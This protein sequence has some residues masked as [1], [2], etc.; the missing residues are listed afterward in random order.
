MTSHIMLGAGVVTMGARS[1]EITAMAAATLQE[2]SGGRHVLGIG[3]GTSH[4][5]PGGGTS[6]RPLERLRAYIGVVRRVLEGVTVDDEEM[7][8]V[9]GFALGL[10]VEP[11]P[12]WIAALGDRAIALGGEVAD[13][14]LMNMCTPERVAQACKI[15]DEAAERAGR[16]PS[17]VTMAVYVRACLGVE[18]AVALPALRD[19]TARYAALPPYRR[20]F[21]AMGQ[22]DEADAAAR[23]L[24]AGR[25]D[26]VPAP[27]VQAV[28]VM[29]GRREAMDRFAAYRQAGADLV[30][31][32]PVLAL[33]PFSSILGTVMAAAPS[34]AVEN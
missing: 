20:Q 25:L 5:A 24:E 31:C 11:P 10:Q 21:H 13:G 12:I 16:D 23:A 3:T 6:D 18:G 19:A 27:L 26:E 32:Y 28:M 17:S 1:P 2:L 30:L 29:G 15:R 9:S 33:D 4:A 14:I 34:A 8:G 22:G 7:F